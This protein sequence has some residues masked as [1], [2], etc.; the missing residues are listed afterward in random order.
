MRL[1]TVVSVEYMHAVEHLQVYITS[2]IYDV[3]HTVL[4]HSYLRYFTLVHS[5]CSWTARL[6][7]PASKHDAMHCY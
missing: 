1:D 5:N 2:V 7:T 4:K 6:H 3:K